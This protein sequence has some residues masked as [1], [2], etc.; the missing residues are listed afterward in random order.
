M[1]DDRTSIFCLVAIASVSSLIV[2]PAWRRDQMC[3]P[4]FYPFFYRSERRA[5]PSSSPSTIARS[6]WLMDSVIVATSKPAARASCLIITNV[7]D[8]RIRVS[9][10][11]YHQIRHFAARK[12][13]RVGDYDACHGVRSVGKFVARTNITGGINPGISR[14]QPIIYD[15]ALRGVLH[16]RAR[17]IP[18]L[19]YWAFD[20]PPPKSHHIQ[21]LSRRAADV[22][23]IGSFAA[24]L[25]SPR[26]EWQRAASPEH[27]P[28][29]SAA[30][31]TAAASRSSLGR[32]SAPSVTI[33]TWLPKR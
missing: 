5:K 28:F 2:S 12:K 21:F 22:K 19:P 31:T 26:C 1:V 8:F 15:D 14:P 33:V 29:R 9:A 17:P 20:P 10:P 13:Q 23:L 24:R 25:C 27:R 30:R 6:T 3:R 18:L 16:A 32:I 7:S 11:R 4:E